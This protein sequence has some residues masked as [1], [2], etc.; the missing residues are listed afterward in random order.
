M[1]LFFDIETLPADKARESVVRDVY[2]KKVAKKGVERVGSYE[3][4]LRYTS[5][6][7]GLGRIFCIGYALDDKPAEALH[8]E[9]EKQLLRQFWQLTSEADLFIGHNVFDF[10]LPFI[11]QRSVVHDIEPI[12]DLFPRRYSSDLVYDTYHEWTKWHMARKSGSLDYLASVFGLPSSKDGIDGSQVYDF[13]LAGR[14]RE[15]IEYCKRDVELTRQIFY[16]L[17]FTK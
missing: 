11:Y 6:D 15:I 14:G 12:K 2:K 10:D 9:D 7:G 4:F 8:G 16:R 13:Y 5:M 1:K 17:T 3:D